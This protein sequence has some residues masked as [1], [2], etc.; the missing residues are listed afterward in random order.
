[1]FKKMDKI[2]LFTSLA[3]FIFGLVMV[4]SASSVTAYNSGLSPNYYFI[5]QLV[6]LLAGFFVALF[7][8][9]FNLKSEGWISF[10]LIFIVTGALIYL[11]FYGTPINNAKSWIILANGSITIQPS[12]FAK[13]ISIVWIPF[14]IYSQKQYTGWI[15]YIIVCIFVVI[16]SFF[17]AIEPDFGTAVIYG[18]ICLTLF[19]VINEN[20]EIKVK[21]MKFGGAF[22]ILIL[23]A[24]IILISSNPKVFDRQLGRIQALGTNPC[25]EENFYDTGTQRCNGFIAFNNGGLTGKGLGDST[26]KYLYLPEAYTDFIFPI[27]VE[28]TGFICGALSLILMGVVLFRIFRIAKKASTDNGKVICIGVF[29]Y[30]LI[31]MFVNLGGILGIIPL[32]GVPLPFLSY[33]GSYTM[34][35][36]ASLAFVQRVAIETYN[37]K[38]KKVTK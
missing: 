36:V 34:C 18:L 2:L 7:I 26:Q 5:R 8:M 30:I 20:H 33:G 17:I 32:T 35:L 24:V 27:V 9:S 14:M 21:I 29:I 3:L 6:F 1:M 11:I 38:N 37:D 19:F 28:E 12:E 4:F 13:V 31:H 10:G 15:K 23:F 22:L 25:S 16:I